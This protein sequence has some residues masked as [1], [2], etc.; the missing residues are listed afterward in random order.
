MQAMLLADARAR[1]SAGNNNPAKIEIIAITTSSST[2]VKAFFRLF[3]AVPPD[4]D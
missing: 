1:L 3:I 4:R 2:N